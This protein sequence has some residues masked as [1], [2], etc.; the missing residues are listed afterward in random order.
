M[1]KK[2]SSFFV[3]GRGET[4]RLKKDKDYNNIWEIFLY[5]HHTE[6]ES[7]DNTNNYCIFTRHISP[8]KIVNPNTVTYG[9]EITHIV[10]AGRAKYH[11]RY[12]I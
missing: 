10:R 12:Y 11:L 6:R 1:K 2:K 5:R 4:S 9:T 3:Q 8:E 7:I